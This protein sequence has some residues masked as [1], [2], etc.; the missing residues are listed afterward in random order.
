MND[1]RKLLAEQIGMLVIS[2]AEISASL[3][4]L[5]AKAEAL[6]KLVDA[7]KPGSVPTPSMGQNS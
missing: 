3:A 6:Q 4:Q 7:E 2:N 5:Q 1:P